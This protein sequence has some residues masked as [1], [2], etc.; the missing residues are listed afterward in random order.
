MGS[1]ENL[2]ETQGEENAQE[3]LTEKDE[4]PLE[5]RCLNIYMY[6]YI[7]ILF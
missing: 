1:K 2:T 3:E 6:I 5:E 4:L 7:A